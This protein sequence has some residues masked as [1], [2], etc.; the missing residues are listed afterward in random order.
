MIVDSLLLLTPVGYDPL[1][2]DF[3]YHGNGL[4]KA[5]LYRWNS[6]RINI[7]CTSSNATHAPANWY[8]SNGTRI[9]V[10]DRNFRAGHFP[11]G[12]AMLQIA[13]Y[14]SLSYCDGGNYTC[15]I[16]TTSGHYETRTFNLV[17][18]CT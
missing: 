8:F 3:G 4:D 6:D 17:V 12:T 13:H 10:R 2:T 5:V 14:R 18:D 1:I 11:N 16:N 15:I 7:H 9:G